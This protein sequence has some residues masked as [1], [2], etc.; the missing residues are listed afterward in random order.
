MERLKEGPSTVMPLPALVCNQ[1][2]GLGDHDPAIC[3]GLD[4][5]RELGVA[6]DGE[7]RADSGNG[8]DSN[9]FPQN[10]DI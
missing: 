3:R 9:C 8:V 6:V 10:R 4:D 2:D 7:R 1:L 5:K